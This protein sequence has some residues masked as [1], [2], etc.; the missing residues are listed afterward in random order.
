MPIP[1]SFICPITSDVMS[2]PVI[3]P[4]GNSYERAA[5]EDWLTRSTTSPVTRTTLTADDLIPNRA[6]RESIEEYVASQAASAAAPPLPPTA[7]YSSPP[8]A[9]APPLPPSHAGAATPSASTAVNVGHVVV[10]PSVDGM[11]DVCAVVTLA[12]PT[13]P[14]GGSRP[15]ADICCVVDVSGSMGAD[16]TM[17]N[18]SGASESHGLSLLDIV[19]HALRTIIKTLAPTDRL[20][21]V[22]YS[23]KARI[24]CPL[25][26]MHNSGILKAQAAVNNLASGGQ[27]NLWDGLKTGLD[28]LRD[29]GADVASDRTASVLLLTDGLPNM[30]P[31]R[32][33]VEMLRRYVDRNLSSNAMA[34]I[35]LST[36]GFGYSLDSPLLAELATE[37]EGSYSF[38]PDSSLVGTVFVHALANALAVSALK[39]RLTITPCI[40]GARFVSGTDVVMGGHRCIACTD[41]AGTTPITVCPGQIIFGQ[42]KDV[43]VRMSVPTAALPAD[44]SLTTGVVTAS[45]QYLASPLLAP[46]VVDSV[47][48]AATDQH[49]LEAEIC[50]LT[51][52]EALRKAVVM[53]KMSDLDG[54]RAAIAAA[55]ATI[56]TTGVAAAAAS[57][58]AKSP[59]ATASYA[60]SPAHRVRA[61]LL[62]MRGQ[63]SEALS[64]PDW[65]T[66]WGVHYLPS[67]M[68]AHLMQSCNNF[69]DPGVQ[70]YG[71]AVFEETRDA[72]DE[73]FVSLP[74]PKPAPRRAGYG[75]RSGSAARATPRAPVSM[76]S[77]HSACGPCF[78]GS[79][80]VRLADGTTKRVDEVVKGDVI[81][82]PAAVGS[83][84][85]V[86]CIL[87]TRCAG[88]ATPLVEVPSTSL[89]VTPWHPIVAATAG[90]GTNKKW[91]F[92]SS[93][94][95]ATSRPCDAVY[96]FVLSNMESS[97]VIDATEVITLGHGIKGDE[98]ASHEYWGSHRVVD[99]LTKM[100]GWEN[101]LVQLEPGC[102]ERDAST[103]RACGLRQ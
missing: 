42:A 11:S 80:R 63:V 87:R 40:K 103:G 1:T 94:G 31:P 71:S 56:E 16:A 13:A 58:P 33:E 7:V 60:L 70:V 91:I 39:T 38:I 50:R 28:L 3:D 35:A 77:Y 45:L 41:D 89:L 99:D 49:A 74:P 96:S 52:V 48:T 68:Q 10:G 92:P 75:S 53:G 24:V 54:A 90:T 64:R 30:S 102:V 66:K 86:A 67:L 22:A 4:E 95:K 21:I 14:Q 83:R 20:A 78:E 12:P 81:D 37:G 32:G 65:F 101:G 44:G 100:V 82:S 97:M 84:A 19:K 9:S 93:L 57:L 15:G 17:K 55:L 61:L 85:E 36:F 59:L 8:D 27:T 76:S 62:D 72:A 18:E 29:A 51:A 25:G 73:I 46:S 2:D 79:G 98:V 69:K 23:T 34:H 47:A 43:V 5:I 26:A 88:G 6:L